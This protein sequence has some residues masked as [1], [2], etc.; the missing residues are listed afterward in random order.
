MNDALNFLYENRW[1]IWVLFLILVGLLFLIHYLLWVFGVGRF[2]VDGAPKTQQSLRVVFADAIVKIINDFRHLLAL[3]IVLVFAAA[4]GYALYIGRVS[5]EGS[6]VENLK[7]ALQGVMATLGGLVGSIIGYYF[8]ESSKTLS[9]SNQ[10]GTQPPATPT[11]PPIQ[12][13]PD[14]TAT[15]S[16]ISEA[17]PPPPDA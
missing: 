8:G 6:A 7:E 4:L 3:V 11:T 9:Q 15:S 1:G 10:S 17:P 2:G 13:P 12:K 16:P 5:T 14:P